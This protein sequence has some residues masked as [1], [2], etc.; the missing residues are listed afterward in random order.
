MT[1]HSY[2]VIA[3]AVGCVGSNRYSEVRNLNNGQQ[4]NLDFFAQTSAI[5]QATEVLVR[6]ADKG[7]YDCASYATPLSFS[8]SP[9]AV[10]C[11]FADIT[12]PVEEVLDARCDQGGCSVV[13][14]NKTGVSVTG[15]VEGTFTL[16][17]SARLA[18][19][20]LLTDSAS[21]GFAP[22]DA[23]GLECVLEY[24]CPGPNAIFP[25]SSFSYNAQPM[26]E[27]DTLAGIVSVTAEPAGI[28]EVTSTNGQYTV[29]GLK[30]GIVTLHLRSGQ[31]ERLQTIRVAALEEVVFG[32][33]H[34]R[35]SLPCQRVV[36]VDADANRLG[37]VAPA[38]IT[39]W[40]PTFVLA[41]VL[42]DGSLAVGGA[43]RL[44]TPT[45]GATVQVVGAYVPLPSDFSLMN[46]TVGGL[47][48]AICHKGQHKIV[49]SMGNARLDYSFEQVCD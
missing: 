40:G 7:R 8:G 14:S 25:G 37:E 35:A 27:G 36:C 11:Q 20:T 12:S 39:A 3:L 24:S 30:E 49:A 44:T 18:D 29:R 41:W 48:G 1:K 38:K 5:G 47:E 19:G 43:G 9:S 16:S 2:L 31:V 21:V 46:F 6:R 26:N 17:V 28:V 13:I 15:L 34:L 33:V 10:R 23:I 45:P 32:Q 22:V 4:G 42:R